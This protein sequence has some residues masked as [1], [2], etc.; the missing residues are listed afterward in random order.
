MITIFWNVLH[1]EGENS[2]KPDGPHPHHKRLGA[3][4]R[5]IA[6]A[7]GDIAGQ[8]SCDKS[9]SVF[10]RGKMVSVLECTNE[11]VAD[12]PGRKKC[13]DE[14]HRGSHR[15]FFDPFERRW[16]VW[17]SCCGLLYTVNMESI[18]E[19]NA[20]SGFLNSMSEQI[21]EAKESIKLEGS[22]SFE[23][24]RDL[25]MENIASLLK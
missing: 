6:Y 4:R 17:W 19:I 2:N 3:Q 9:G 15:I 11:C 13:H 18:Q 1:Y 21:L 12:L 8:P 10:Q 20:N 14:F 5:C 16:L 23:A 24:M 7:I 22:K 25:F